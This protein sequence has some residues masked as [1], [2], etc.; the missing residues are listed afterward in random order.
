MSED[1]QKEKLN[2]F[3]IQEKKDRLVKLGSEIADIQKNT[4]ELKAMF[5]GKDAA[6]P[7]LKSLEAAAEQSSCEIS[8]E[9]ADISKIKFATASPSQKNE[10]DTTNDDLTTQKSQTASNAKPAQKPDE[11]APLKNYPAFSLTITGSYSSTVDFLNSMENLPYF[12]R[13][14]KIDVIPGGKKQASDYFWNP[15]GAW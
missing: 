12:V 9:P 8:I 3:V 7:L 14:L 11:L 10:T 2:S 6:L 5:L 1:Y 15:C 13:P 4:D